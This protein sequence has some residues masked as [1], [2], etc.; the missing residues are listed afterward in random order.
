[1]KHFNGGNSIGMTEKSKCE[2]PEEFKE[3]VSMCYY[4]KCI[5]YD[6]LYV[7][8]DKGFVICTHNILEITQLRFCIKNEWY[9]V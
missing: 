9:D 8:S 7:Y 4:E 6:K 2:N 5:C 1:M 3:Q